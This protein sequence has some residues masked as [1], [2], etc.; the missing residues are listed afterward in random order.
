MRHALELQVRQILKGLAGALDGEVS[1]QNGPSQ[2][3]CDLQVN[4]MRGGQ[5]LTAHPVA[6]LPP[7]AVIIGEHHYQE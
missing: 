3:R 2:H 6:R 5:I 1:P 7:S 4:E